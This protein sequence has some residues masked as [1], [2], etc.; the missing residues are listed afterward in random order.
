MPEVLNRIKRARSQGLDVTADIY[1]YIAGSTS[2]SACLPPWALEGGTE[3]MLSRLRDPETRKRLK[4]EI[5]VDS[6][7]WENIYLG[8][9]GPGGVLVGGG[10]NTGAGGEA[11][12]TVLGIG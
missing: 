8:S 12:E 5:S 4:W 7:D 3:N 1:P 9:G 2:L 6:R 11:R 10:G